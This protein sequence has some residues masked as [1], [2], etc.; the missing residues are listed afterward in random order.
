[1]SKFRRIKFII[2]NGKFNFLDMF[3]NEKRKESINIR[4]YIN[5]KLKLIFDNKHGNNIIIK[6]DIL[7]GELLM[8]SKVIYFYKYPKEK[9]EKE[10]ITNIIE[11]TY[12]IFLYKISNKDFKKLF[13]I[14]VFHQKTKE[15]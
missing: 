15:K 6:N 14:Y 11:L 12:L 5:D 4:Y 10:I 9:I 3:Y 1:M 2:F 7:K 8:E 13:L